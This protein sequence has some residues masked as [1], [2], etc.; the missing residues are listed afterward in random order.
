MYMLA[1]QFSG[2]HI[3]WHELAPATSSEHVTT[4]SRNNS[5]W[6]WKPMRP[7]SFA[8]KQSKTKTYF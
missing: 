6:I 4:L 2:R 8:F 5:D 1:C 7:K 3:S